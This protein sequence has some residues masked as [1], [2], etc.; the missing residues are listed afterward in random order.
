MTQN[1]TPDEQAAMDDPRSIADM[2]AELAAATRRREC[3]EWAANRVTD[4]DTRTDADALRDTANHHQGTRV[5]AA[6]ADHG[7]QLR[8]AGLVGKRGGLTRRGSIAAER[9]RNQALDDAFGPL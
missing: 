6:D 3:I 5:H 7:R 9:L 2:A 4:P 8:R 1:L